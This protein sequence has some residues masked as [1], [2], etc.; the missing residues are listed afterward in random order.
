M[1][2]QAWASASV[3]KRLDDLRHN[4]GK[5]ISLDEIGNM[6]AAI[7]HE[8][9]DSASHEH[10][11]LVAELRSILDY[12][13]GAKQELASLG[14][15]NLSAKEIPAAADQLDAI[16]S[17]TE[18]AATTIMDAAEK[19]EEVAEKS[20]EKEAAELRDISMTLFEASSFQDICGQRIT[21]VMT[22]LRVLEEKLSALAE[23]L[24]DTRIDEADEEVTF[25]ADG[26]VEDDKRLLDGPQ[27]DGEG[28][29]QAEIDAIMAEFD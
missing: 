24:G 2:A 8:V 7:V 25:D 15:K 23:S 12:V 20:G 22:M 5:N 19:M 4:L 29:S 26:L 18:E 10:E 9:C 1:N 28:T 14:P 3:N 16:V 11:R 27:L 17:A 13:I 6:A 21:K